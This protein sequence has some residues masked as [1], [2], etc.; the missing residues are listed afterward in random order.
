MESNTFYQIF[1]NHALYSWVICGFVLDTVTFVLLLG[2]V[3]LLYPK[4]QQWQSGQTKATQMA[5]F[6]KI[7]K[8]KKIEKKNNNKNQSNKNKNESK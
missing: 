2:E 4:N 5:A 7:T 3:Q 8:P 6:I 1:S